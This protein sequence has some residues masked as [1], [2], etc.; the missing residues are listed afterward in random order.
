MGNVVLYMDVNFGG[1][2][3]TVP[4]GQNIPCLPPPIYGAASSLI[5]DCQQWITLWETP[6]YDGGDDSAWI[7]APGPGK[8]WEISN[9]VGMWRPHGSNNW[10]DLFK[11][12]SFSGPTSGD[13]DNQ[14]WLYADGHYGG[15]TGL[16]SMVWGEKYS[17]LL[18]KIIKLKDG[19]A[20]RR[21]QLE[22]RDV[23]S[24]GIRFDLSS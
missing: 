4:E 9:F 19:P 20:P 6:N 17:E 14:I 1:G 2:S 21:P 18:S 13:V 10:N 5:S 7:Q 23:T 24:S 11:A 8:H 16:M 22:I 15:N 3:F 12:I